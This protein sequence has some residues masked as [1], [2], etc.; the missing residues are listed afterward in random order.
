MTAESILRQL[1]LDALMSYDGDY[2]IIL[3]IPS[4]QGL[5]RADIE[6]ALASWQARLAAAS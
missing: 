3:R 4:A 5:S 6:D 1:R 2:D